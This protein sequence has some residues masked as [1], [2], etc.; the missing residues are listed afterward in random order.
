MV[1]DIKKSFKVEDLFLKMDYKNYN[2][3]IEI[4][5]SW[6]SINKLSHYEDV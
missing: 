4:R 1:A 3:Y 6:C 2:Y 5:F